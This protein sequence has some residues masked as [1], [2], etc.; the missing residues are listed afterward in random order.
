MHWRIKLEDQ[1]GCFWLTN[2]EWRCWSDSVDDAMVF[3]RY[4]KAA[5]AAALVK[6]NVEKYID[7]FP[8]VRIVKFK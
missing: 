2:R 5:V 6:T 4:E 7:W 1:H 8:R 3:T